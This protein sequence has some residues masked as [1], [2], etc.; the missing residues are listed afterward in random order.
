MDPGFAPAAG[1][2][3]PFSTLRRFAAAAPEAAGEVERCELCGVRLAPEHRHLL[4]IG[5]RRVL[6]S[7]AP[8]ALLFESAV[9]GR[10]KPIPRDA[11]ALPDFVLSDLTWE[12]FALPI[13]L[14]FFFYSTPA[15]KMVA[16]YPSPAGAT[17][18]LLPLAAW[19]ALV[20]D[21]PGLRQIAP[22]VEALLINRVGA[23]R[24]YF[25]APIDACFELVGLIRYHWRGLSGGTE[26]WREIEG[27]F[28]RL[29]ERSRPL[30]AEDVA[31]GE[32]HA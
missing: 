26:A 31:A 32:N 14:A 19:Q 12:G 18:S 2:P 11:H 3:S 6:C 9:G 23:A 7:C 15:Q 21:N 5:S 13:N 24:E 4:E 10:F 25:V 20:A 30:A 8:C 29:R 28:A 17:E 1:R 27:F 22:D 16:L